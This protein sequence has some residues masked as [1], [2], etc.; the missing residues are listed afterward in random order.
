MVAGQSIVPKCAGAGNAPGQHQRG[1]CRVSPR[2]S[3][4]N[5]D[6]HEQESDM[7][8]ISVFYAAFGYL[9]LLGAILW[10]MLF[11]GD[12]VVFPNMDAAGTAAP[13]QGIFVDLGLLLLLALLHRSVSR[14]MLRHFVRRSIP[15]GLER[16]T[17]AWAAAVVLGLIY[18]GWQPLP[19]L[20]WSA[21]GSL[22]WAL[23]GLFYL[24]WTL[25]LIGAFLASHLDLFEITGGA[26]G[27]GAADDDGHLRAAGK[28]ASTDTLRQPLYGGILIAVWAT[29]VMTVGHLLLASAVTAYLLIDGLWA[30]RKRGAARESRGAFSLQGQRVAR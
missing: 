4:L 3:D 7:G 23:C 12:S 20:L 2:K 25:I 1:R 6:T 26:G 16:S 10:G 5:T 13:L 17:Q 14:G 24:T 8:I 11:V 29:S 22:R 28:V 27:A 15:R 21:T 9:A 18:A 30:A 19:Q